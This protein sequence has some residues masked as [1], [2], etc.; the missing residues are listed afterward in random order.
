[1]ESLAD[2]L[3]SNIDHR[4]NIFTNLYLAIIDVG[5]QIFVL[6]TFMQQKI[7]LT[8]T[9]LVWSKIK[10]LSLKETKGDSKETNGDKDSKINI[11]IWVS[12]NTGQEGKRGGAVAIFLTLLHQLH[13]LQKYLDIRWVITA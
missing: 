6:I 11:F 3:K 1:M 13:S 2:N 8:I 12:Q 7:T 4:K 5:I 10:G 9:P